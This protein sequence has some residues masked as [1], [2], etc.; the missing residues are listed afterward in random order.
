VFGAF[1]LDTSSV[2]SWGRAP[3][4]APKLLVARDKVA[5][6]LGIDTGDLDPGDPTIDAAIAAAATQQPTTDDAAKDGRRKS[7]YGFDLHALVRAPGLGEDPDLEAKL[8]ERIDLTPAHQDVVIPSLRL[9]DAVLASGVC[10]STNCS[11]TGITRTSV[12]I[13]GRRN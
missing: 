12:P 5:R 6:D 4:K 9:I 10:G 7:F 3:R 13:G 1:A 11:L 8:I 2:W